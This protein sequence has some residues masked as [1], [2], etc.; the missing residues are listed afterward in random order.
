M[1]E[2]VQHEAVVATFC[3]DADPDHTGSPATVRVTGHRVDQAKHDPTR[4]RFMRDEIVAGTLPQG[5]P[6]SVTARVYGVNP[7]LWRV[8]AELST[9]SPRPGHPRP[10][11]PATSASLVRSSAWSWRRWT[12]VPGS[13]GPVAT[14]V[15]PL[16]SVIRTPAVIPFIWP[17]LVGVGS[18]IGLVAQTWLA[19]RR[20]PELHGLLPVTLIATVAGIVLA[21][22]WY[23]A[24]HHKFDGWCIQGFLLG[25]PG[26]VAIAALTGHV[27]LGPFA[28]TMTPGLFAG[29]AVGRIGCFFAGCCAGRPTRSRW[30]IWSSDR[31]VGM[32][33]IPTQLL[34]C[35][36]CLVIGTAA[37]LLVL[38]DRPYPPGSMFVAAVA[39]YTLIRQGVLRL[40]SEPR[41]SRFG[42]RVVAAI[43]AI[44]LVVDVAVLLR[45]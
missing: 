26:A 39:T 8:G 31:R 12:L 11:K 27:P 38:S 30:G 5:G 19:T 18:L 16:A 7:G 20:H 4:D 9:L 43:S 3:F 1:S 23:M 40:R 10:R 37:L 6:V 17:T 34:E 33:R 32:R 45:A 2:T 44:A 24:L 41:R 22:G 36:L 14:C 42:S 25:A 29:M 28:D 13:D 35:A 15:V 21:K